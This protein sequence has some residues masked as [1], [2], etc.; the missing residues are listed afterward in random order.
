MSGFGGPGGGAG[1]EG[2]GGHGGMS[3]NGVITGA[4][5]KKWKQDA[6][7]AFSK[8]KQVSLLT[9]WLG[10]RQI[11]LAGAEWIM[12]STDQSNQCEVARLLARQCTEDRAKVK[13]QFRNHMHSDNWTTVFGK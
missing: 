13:A 5:A 7:Y 12:N 4:E 9:D 10:F 3:G 6:Q 11:D 1:A 2:F 8:P